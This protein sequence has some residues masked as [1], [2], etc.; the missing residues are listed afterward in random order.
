[1]M[2]TFLNDKQFNHITRNG[3][4]FSCDL[5]GPILVS[6]HNS[7]Q[8]LALAVSE[9]IAYHAMNIWPEL[10]EFQGYDALTYKFNNGD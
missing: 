9:M 2:R 6:K 4:E 1:M 3:I 10:N 7:T 5:R 8:Q